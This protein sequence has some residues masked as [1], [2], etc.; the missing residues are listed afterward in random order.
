MVQN[1]KSNFRGKMAIVMIILGLLLIA[2][3]L[4][5]NT[6]IDYGFV[7]GDNEGLKVFASTQIVLN[8]IGK[9]LAIDLF[10]DP[11]G[12]VLVILGL[13]LL[14]EKIY[15][16]KRGIVFSVVGIISNLLLMFIPLII[17]Q[18]KLAF[19]LVAL[20]LIQTLCTVGIMYS[21]AIVCSKM[22]DQY[23]YMQVE[24]DLKFGAEL[25]GVSIVIANILDLL[26]RIDWYFASILV[27]IVKIC[28]IASMMY[29]VIK[30]ALY[31]RNFALFK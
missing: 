15:Y 22:V 27:I 20:F 23:K 25:Y 28:A 6:D 5:I 31:N 11:I 14:N 19:P 13:C 8:Y 26:T 30:L 12:Y 18:E 21:L 3:K 17:S 10:F 1:K 7:I 2:F 29:F 16:I 9:S 4:N 24:K